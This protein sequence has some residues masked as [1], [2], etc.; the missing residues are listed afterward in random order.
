VEM[1]LASRIREEMRSEPRHPVITE[2][3]FLSD[4]RHGDSDDGA[5]ENRVQGRKTMKVLSPEIS[6]SASS[7]RPVTRHSTHLTSW[8]DSGSPSGSESGSV[9]SIESRTARVHANSPVSIDNA[10]LQRNRA[11]PVYRRSV[12]E[13]DLD[14]LAFGC[15]VAFLGDGSSSLFSGARSSLAPFGLTADNLGNVC[16]GS[17]NAAPLSRSG[18]ASE[19]YPPPPHD[20]ASASST[21]PVDGINFRTGMSGHRGLNHLANKSATSHY[22][23]PSARYR[24]TRLMSEHRGVAWPS[25]SRRESPPRPPANPIPMPPSPSATGSVSSSGATIPAL[26]PRLSLFPHTG[27]DQGL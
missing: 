6:P 2:L 5:D 18:L 22:S 1:R 4:R 24:T 7:E 23:P 12:S 9:N 26:G 27:T 13:D 14:Q 17:G 8:W 10:D 21:Q 25:S 15:G 11:I 19:D 16:Q 3:A 20:Y